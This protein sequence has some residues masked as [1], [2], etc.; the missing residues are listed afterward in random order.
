MA[1][2]VALLLAGHVA[3]RLLL[4]AS[5]G[6]PLEAAWFAGAKITPLIEGGQW[7]RLVLAPLHHLT[8]A[9]LAVNAVMIAL[10]GALCARMLGAA[11]TVGVFLG[12]AWISTL[13]SAV[14]NPEAWSL[15]ASGGGYGLTGALIGALAAGSLLVGWRSQLMLLLAAALIGL[16]I[17]QAGPEADK[18]AHGAGLLVGFLLGVALEGRTGRVPST[19]PNR[20]LVVSGGLAALGL[21]VSAEARQWLLVEAVESARPGAGTP[22]H[23]DLN[24]CRW[25]R[26]PGWVTLA[27][28]PDRPQA[29]CITNGLAEACLLPAG[30]SEAL[31]TQWFGNLDCPP[32]DRRPDAAPGETGWHLRRRSLA[33]PEAPHTRTLWTHGRL[34]VAFAEAHLPDFEIHPQA[35]PTLVAL[36]ESVECPGSP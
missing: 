3:T 33:R 19:G 9:H 25:T 26:P 10:M 1:T 16:H 12:T 4:P 23:A 31:E 18:T 15:G 17:A 5:P 22:T 7:W 27:P 34:P 29:R 13:V 8:G 14:L 20:R 28:D 2:L 6:N 24:G 11:A 36:R 21:I 35:L 30:D 32:G